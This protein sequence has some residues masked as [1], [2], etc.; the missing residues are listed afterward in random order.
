MK[1]LTDDDRERM[2][3]SRALPEG[4]DASSALHSG[5]TRP[6]QPALRLMTEVPNGPP[7]GESPFSG[8]TAQESL[9]ADST[10]APSN[11]NSPFTE[12]TMTPSSIIHS[13]CESIFSPIESQ[14]LIGSPYVSQESDPGNLHSFERKRSLPFGFHT[15]PPSPM[16]KI[17][18][19]MTRLRAD[20]LGL[21]ARPSNNIQHSPFRGLRHHSSM[22]GLSRQPVPQRRPPIQ[23][24]V[25]FGG[26][27]PFTPMPTASD[28][29]A[30]T[31]QQPS[32]LGIS[33]NFNVE[34]KS[35]VE[36]G[37]FP[38]EQS[39][40]MLHDEGTGFH[41]SSSNF[42]PDASFAN[43]GFQ[44]SEF[45]VQQPTFQSFEDTYSQTMMQQ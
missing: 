35:I 38:T 27:N 1:R 11:A 20:S 37:S 41:P 33:M 26:Y 3:Q 19:G 5:F 29:G 32:G 10:L 4:F 12:Y 44:R 17:Q 15:Q 14:S 43:G 9:F 34:A 40:P 39:Y 42:A 36:N 25:S 28:Y 31:A 24:S 18:R 16:T 45:G 21:P 2:M 7:V 6:S 23:T 13:P 8:G 22:V 30:H